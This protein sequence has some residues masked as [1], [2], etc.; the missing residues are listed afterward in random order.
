MSEATGDP[1]TAFFPPTENKEFNDSL[2]GKYDS[3]C[4][5]SVRFYIFGLDEEQQEHDSIE[6]SEDEFNRHPC[7]IDYERHTVFQ[8]GARQIC[9]TKGLPR[10]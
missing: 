1:Y 2:N 10:C 4:E 8:N 7:T 9:L 5:M 3:F 6:V